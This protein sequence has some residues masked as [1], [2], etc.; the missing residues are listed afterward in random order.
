MSIHPV[1]AILPATD[2]QAAERGTQTAVSS[3]PVSAADNVART[4]SGPKPKQEFPN[5]PSNSTSTEMPADEVQVQRDTT[6][7]E[8]VIK[9]LDRSGNVILQ[10]P[11]SQVLDVAHAIEQDFQQQAK[12]RTDETGTQVGE[13]GQVYGD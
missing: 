7:T 4:D 6:T 13:G 12:V 5:P 3:D 9:Y 1:T 11:S 2:A 10:V 8:I